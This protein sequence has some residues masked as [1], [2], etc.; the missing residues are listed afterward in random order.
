LSERY[1]YLDPT[2]KMQG[3]YWLSQIRKFY[4]NG[5]IHQ[6]TEIC[7]TQDPTWH[8]ASAFPEVMLASKEEAMELSQ[9]QLR[10]QTAKARERR[11]LLYAGVA[12]G[13]YVFY[14]LFL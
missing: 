10:Q 14:L 13:A 5:L 2:G 4:D 1:H 11:F 6:R 8:P 3:P 9:I 7:T 12:I